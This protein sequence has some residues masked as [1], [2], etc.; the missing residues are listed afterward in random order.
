MKKINKINSASQIEIVEYYYKLINKFDKIFQNDFGKM[1]PDFESGC[2]Q[3][4][5]HLIYNKFKKDLY[6]EFI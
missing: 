3:C 2:A 4:R 1:C 6:D 5:A